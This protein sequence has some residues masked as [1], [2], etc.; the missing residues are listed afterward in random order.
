MQAIVHRAGGSGTERLVVKRLQAED[1]SHFFIEPVKSF[2]IVLLD[3]K[4]LAI[5][6]PELLVAMIFKLT[7]QSSDHKVRRP[8]GSPGSTGV[9]GQ[10]LAAT[11]LPDLDGC[12]GRPGIDHLKA[13]LLELFA[14]VCFVSQFSPLVGPGLAPAS[15]FTKADPAGRGRPYTLMLE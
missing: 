9:A 8:E 10:Q 13:R 14:N 2:Q 7:I 15:S 6:I 4:P 5:V 12:R 1:G 11:V 3:R